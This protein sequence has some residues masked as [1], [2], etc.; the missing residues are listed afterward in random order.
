MR[1]NAAP[2]CT[3]DVEQSLQANW[4]DFGFSGVREKVTM[5]SPKLTLN[6]SS[7]KMTCSLMSTSYFPPCLINCS[8]PGPRS[9][10]A[11][12]KVRRESL[13]FRLIIA[14]FLIGVEDRG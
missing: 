14:A 3:Q 5:A 6:R 1:E 12:R 9:L 10:Q 4:R 11:S 13:S 7:F 8:P 2:R